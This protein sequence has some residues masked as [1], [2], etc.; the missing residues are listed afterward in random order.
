MDIVCVYGEGGGYF[1]QNIT[2]KKTK[3]WLWKLGR[4]L[5]KYLV[6]GHFILKYLIKFGSES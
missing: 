5:L 1:F 2:R 4:D 6:I 3:T